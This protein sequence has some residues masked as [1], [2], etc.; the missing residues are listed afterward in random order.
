MASRVRRMRNWVSVG[1]VA[2]STGLAPWTAH[3]DD[4][5]VEGRQF[6]LDESEASRDGSAAIGRS[7]LASLTPGSVLVAQSGA[8]GASA[9]TEKWKFRLG[10]YLWAPRMKM[11]LDVSEV[12][13]STTIDFVDIVPQLH[14]AFG[15]QA[16]ATVG[17]WTA[18]GDL[19]YMSVGQ[20]ET[21]DGISVSTNVQLLFFEFGATYRLGP[22]SLGRA[23]WLT[24]EPL[25]GGRFIW[26]DVSL[27]FPNRKVSDSASVIDPI[28]GGRITY[29][30]TNT[31]QIW[32]RGDVGGF[33]ISDNQTELTYNLIAGLNWRF[34]DRWSAFA[35]WRY[36]DIDLEK[37]GGR[38]T[39]NADV[40]M[41]G[42]FLGLSLDF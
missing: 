29:H 18:F 11:T 5:W 4:G 10:P 36:M 40:S 28:V 22:V 9:E 12:I 30:I 3:A 16:E 1:L 24:V 41:S 27:G 21:Q 38:R 32:F 15:A 6:G 34:A 37:N 42:P 7:V 31:L 35:G 33:G 17:K 39:F 13:R 26:M 8:A 2:I 25:A 20:S 19:L 14:F 23:G